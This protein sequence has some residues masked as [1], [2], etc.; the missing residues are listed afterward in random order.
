M[1]EGLIILLIVMVWLNIGDNHTS[2]TTKHAEAI[3]MAV[4]HLIAT[5]NWR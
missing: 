5:A 3:Y 1:I 2:I 4:L